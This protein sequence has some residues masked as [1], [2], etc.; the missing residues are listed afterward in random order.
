MGNVNCCR[1]FFVNAYHHLGKMSS[2]SAR[3]GQSL[4]LSKSS[5]RSSSQTVDWHFS[6]L[7]SIMCQLAEGKGRERERERVAA[8]STSTPTA[9]NSLP[10]TSTSASAKS[11]SYLNAHTLTLPPCNKKQ[12]KT[13][14]VDDE[15]GDVASRQQLEQKPACLPGQQRKRGT[16]Q[17]G[18]QAGTLLTGM[19]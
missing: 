1:L 5:L 4:G 8:A 12:K 3:N 7:G 2:L 19:N 13:L 6:P 10:A 18:R 14:N 15:D 11:R 9:A 17:A 16:R